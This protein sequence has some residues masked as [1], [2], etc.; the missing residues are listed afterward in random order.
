MEG[1]GMLVLTRKSGESVNATTPDEV[2]IKITVLSVKGSQVRL[3][4]EAPENVNIIRSEK[5]TP[6]ELST[7]N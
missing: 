6:P 3:G 2:L 5:A 7:Q 4:F 1:Y